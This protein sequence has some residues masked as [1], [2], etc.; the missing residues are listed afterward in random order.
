MSARLRSR[1]GTGPMWS[2]WAWVSTTASMS[3]SRP[4]IAEK[5]GKITSTPGGAGAWEGEGHATLVG[6]GEQDP[7]VHRQ[8]AARVLEHGHFAAELAEAS[9][10][11]D[12]QAV[13]GQRR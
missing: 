13:S 12:A 4:S 11:D 9:Q 10:R 1:Y 7:A 2:S 5:S 8:Q 3:P 6:L